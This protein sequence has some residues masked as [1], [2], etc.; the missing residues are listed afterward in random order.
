MTYS[1]FILIKKIP[2][3]FN[4]NTLISNIIIY[5]KHLKHSFNIPATIDSV[6]TSKSLRIICRKIWRENAIWRTFSSLILACCIPTR[7]HDINFFFKKKKRN[8][9]KIFGIQER[10]LLFILCSCDREEGILYKIWCFSCQEYLYCSRFIPIEK[11]LTATFSIL[12]C[13]RKILKLR[14]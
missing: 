6:N 11:I 2:Y 9:K 4:I 7:H 10:F 12:Q 3:Y 1:N 13:K 14:V 5:F 8:H